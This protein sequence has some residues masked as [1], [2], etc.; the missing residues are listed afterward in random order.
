LSKVPPKF[1]NTLI[2][3]QNWNEISTLIRLALVVGSQSTQPGNNY[4][5]VPEIVHLVSLVAGEGP[6][7][8]RKSVYGIIM[9]LLQSLYIAR[10]DDS[11][12][13]KLMQLIN[14]C[15]LPEN[16]K[17]FGLQR[18]TPTSEYTN[19]DPL[20]DKDSLDINEDLVKL[21]IRIL[22]DS[23]GSPGQ[24]ITIYD[25]QPPD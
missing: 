17:L 18:E 5:Y 13:P 21:L 4:V 19:L 23:A 1:S 20:N 8:V 24:L 14:D 9:N 22:T 15:T 11:T 10:P 16:L 6:T 3:H 25:V 2:E 12:E 7:L